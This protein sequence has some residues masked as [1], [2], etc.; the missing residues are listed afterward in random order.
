MQKLR[1]RMEQ[2]KDENIKQGLIT[3]NNVRLIEDS[4]NYYSLVGLS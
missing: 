1:G 4:F 2:E 3:A